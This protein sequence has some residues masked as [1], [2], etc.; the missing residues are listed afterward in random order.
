MGGRAVGNTAQKRILKQSFRFS[1]FGDQ[2]L[3]EN[4]FSMA[5]CGVQGGWEQFRE[6]KAGKK[7]MNRLAKGL[8]CGARHGRVVK[9][10][11][12]P[13]AFYKHH[14]KHGDN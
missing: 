1:F 12:V 8:I 6:S 9:K 14:C 4:K 13:S 10:E 11:E 5:E 2:A 7:D 3:L